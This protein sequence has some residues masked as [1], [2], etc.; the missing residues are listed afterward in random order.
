MSK[1]S[2]ASGVCPTVLSRQAGARLSRAPA[3]FSGGQA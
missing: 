3:A 1:S 2:H